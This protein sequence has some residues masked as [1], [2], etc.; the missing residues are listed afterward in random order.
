MTYPQV[1]LEN[2]KPDR[3][4]TLEEYEHSGGYQGLKAAISQHGEAGIHQ[5]IE[6]ANLLGRGGAAFPAGLKIGY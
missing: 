2:R 4:T 6:D 3:I 5:I 1:L